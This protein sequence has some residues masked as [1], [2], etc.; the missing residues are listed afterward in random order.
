LTLGKGITTRRSAKAV[1][2][3]SVF[4]WGTAAVLRIV[5]PFT[6]SS[7]ASIDVISIEVVLIKIVV[8]VKIIVVVDID[9]SAVP[10]AVAPVAAPSAPGGCAQRDS[11]A[12]R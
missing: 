10:I 5:L 9:I 7:L 4:V 8:P 6:L 2:G 3:C 11:R 1:C 12:P